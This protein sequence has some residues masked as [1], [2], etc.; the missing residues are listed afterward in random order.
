MFKCMD[1]K[2]KGKP[3]YKTQYW[4]HQHVEATGHRVVER[5]Y[6]AKGREEVEQLP[7]VVES[8]PLSAMP[9]HKAVKFARQELDDMMVRMKQTADL[10]VSLE[11]RL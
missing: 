9:I 11:N 2:C 1:K 3:K 7:A 10:L 6:S 5:N 4:A 8:K